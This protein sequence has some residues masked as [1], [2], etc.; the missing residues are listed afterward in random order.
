MS[1]YTSPQELSDGL[2]LL[3]SISLISNPYPLVLQTFYDRRAKLVSPELPRF[4]I[5]L[6]VVHTILL[7]VATITF[8]LKVF[9]SRRVERKIWFWRRHYSSLS[10]TP[11]FVPNGFFIIELLQMC[12]CM[13]YLMFV[14]G[15]YW[16]VKHP[17]SIPVYIE[18][19]TM[20]WHTVALVPGA[21]AFWLGGWSAFYVV[22]LAPKA[23]ARDSTPEK[24]SI[25]HPVVLN[26]ICISVPVLITTYFCSVGIALFV[27]L[28]QT[29]DTIGLVTSTLKQLS[30]DWKPN[31]PM[32]AK[33]NARFFNVLTSLTVE[34][35]HL[36]KL[37]QAE[38]TGWAVV[39]IFI[40]AFYIGNAI[41]SGRL[42]KRS[43]LIATGS[44]KLVDHESE[45]Q[46]E[47]KET[48]NSQGKTH[49]DSHLESQ[50]ASRGSAHFSSQAT[51]R[52]STYQNPASM[53]KLQRTYYYLY[54]SCVLMTLFMGLNFAYSITYVTKLRSIIFD[55]KW[56]ERLIDL[57]TST[58]VLLSFSL[59]L[60]S[61]MLMIWG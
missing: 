42:V 15:F 19:G 31:D 37:V 12:G 46:E 43:M 59:F 4:A 29:I 35:N 5:I 9:Q 44:K 33:N 57:I 36:M 34:G 47:S 28:K 7:F 18:A 55:I 54:I 41:A 6:G 16:L 39:S 24:I 48:I 38:G 14:V 49:L 27:K 22:Y 40:I 11:Y 21:I 60:Q 1:V 52:G 3:N 10:T 2:S 23:N 32:S 56:Q 17:E 13:C 45:F 20:F 51:K 25:H 50:A 58:T 30:V 8:L 61:F 26:T 53:R